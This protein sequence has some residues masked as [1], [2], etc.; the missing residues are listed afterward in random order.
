MLLKDFIEGIVP[1]KTFQKGDH[2][3]RQDAH[4]RYFY[5]V[6][7]GEVAIVNSNSEGKDFIQGLYKAGDCFGVAALINDIPYTS[8]AITHT[9]CEIYVINRDHFFRLLKENYSFHLRIT[10]IVC[11]QLQYKTMMLEEIANEEGE[12]RLLTLIHY[13]MARIN[14]D[15]NVLDITKQQL[16]D[17]TGLRVETVIKT[18]KRIEKKGRISTQRGKIVCLSI[19][20]PPL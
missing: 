2:I 4:A 8:A 9:P 5:E 10:Q 13:L 16:A 17:M 11:R 6:R 19:H 15:N 3:Y 18:L 14:P 1:V 12:H 7:D 20:Q